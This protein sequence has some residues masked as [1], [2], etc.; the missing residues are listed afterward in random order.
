MLITWYNNSAWYICLIIILMTN[1]IRPYLRLR[2]L[3]MVLYTNYVYISTL[4]RQ[5]TFMFICQTVNSDRF[6][7]TLFC[8]FTSLLRFGSLNTLLTL[9]ME[10]ECVRKAKTCTFVKRNRWHNSTEWKLRFIQNGACCYVLC[11]TKEFVNTATMV[12]APVSVCA[13][14]AAWSGLNSL[15]VRIR[16]GSL[17]FE[18]RCYR[19]WHT[20][21]SITKLYRYSRAGFKMV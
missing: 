11:L 9:P 13:T 7:E 14:H 8:S 6:L 18:K 3:T 21:I 20:H 1:I 2:K 12:H 16:I 4:Y 17:D 10:K 19:S 5:T 15:P